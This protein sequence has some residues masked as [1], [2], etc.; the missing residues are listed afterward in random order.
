MRKSS[1]ESPILATTN[2]NLGQNNFSLVFLMY[3][4]RSKMFA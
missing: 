3:K 4:M 2:Y 1:F